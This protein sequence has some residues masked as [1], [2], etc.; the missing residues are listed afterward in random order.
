MRHQ[1]N[2]GCQTF[3]PSGFSIL[4]AILPYIT[5][6]IKY[7]REFDH[8]MCNLPIN[9]PV[10]LYVLPILRKLNSQQNIYVL[11]VHNS[12]KNVC[13]SADGDLLCMVVLMVSHD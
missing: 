2:G 12:I 11:F 13:I 5:S 1:Q 10:K 3:D 8:H 7:T 9:G 6:V 4:N